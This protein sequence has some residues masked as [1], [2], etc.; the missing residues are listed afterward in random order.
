MAFP[1]ATVRTIPS[2]QRAEVGQ[3]GIVHLDEKEPGFAR[4]LCIGHAVEHLQGH[5]H[6][7]AGVELLIGC[8]LSVFKSA[9][10]KV[11]Y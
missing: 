9:A 4:L 11:S 5:S 2:F 6:V 1:V 7:A 8:L 10:P 3:T